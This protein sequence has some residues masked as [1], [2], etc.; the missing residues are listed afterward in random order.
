MFINSNP[1]LGVGRVKDVAI[2]FSSLK[3]G[4]GLG[5][6]R[7]IALCIWT[8]VLNFFLSISP[9]VLFI[10]SCFVSLISL[11]SLS[12]FGLFHPP[13][14]P[15]HSLYPLHLSLLFFSFLSFLLFSFLAILLESRGSG[16]GRLVF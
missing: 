7:Q 11:L 15:Y 5:E 2:K 9:C 1:F 10:F 4:L 3:L 14:L 8:Q 13:F 16:G 12:V 6:G